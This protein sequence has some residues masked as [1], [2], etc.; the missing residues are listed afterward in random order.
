MAAWYKYDSTPEQKQAISDLIQGN[1]FTWPTPPAGTSADD[2]K[3]WNDAQTAIKN[4]HKLATSKGIWE[5]QSNAKKI[6]VDKTVFHLAY[7]RH[8]GQLR[9]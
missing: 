7:P 8:L 2:V 6:K 1:K 4:W 5:N 9:L 3:K